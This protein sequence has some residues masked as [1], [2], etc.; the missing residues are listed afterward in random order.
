[1]KK[2]LRRQGLARSLTRYGL[3]A[4]SALAAGVPHAEASIVH[5]NNAFTVSPGQ[6]LHA[7]DI[8]GGGTADFNIRYINFSSLTFALRA[9]N[10]AANGNSRAWVKN[11]GSSFP[12]MKP[13]V[14][15][16]IV[17]PTQAFG[18]TPPYASGGKNVAVFTINGFA[19]GVLSNGEQFVGFK[20]LVGSQT[21]YGWADITLSSSLH[22]ITFNYWAYETSGVGIVVPEPAHAPLGLGLL[23]LG[24]TGVAQYRRRRLAQ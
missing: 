17:G 20:F 16:S 8:D 7:W 11:P 4:G 19:R 10:A 2:L 22:T 18:V 3:A 14:P 12:F 23:A 5:F 6:P 24:A 21:D 13:L 9:S 15:G 1:M